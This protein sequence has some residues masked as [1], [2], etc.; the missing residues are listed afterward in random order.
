[1]GGDA[2]TA[3]SWPWI[4]VHSSGSKDSPVTDG[5]QQGGCGGTLVA[6]GW[7][8]TAAHCFYNQDGSAQTV[9]ADTMSVVI[10]EHTLATSDNV[11]SDND[12]FDTK[13][14]NLEIETMIIHESYGGSNQVHDI[15]LLKLKEKLDLSVYMPAC[16]A[17]AATS[18]T[19]ST[20]WVYGWGNTQSESESSSTL[21]ETTQTILSKADCEAGKGTW[22]GTEYSMA[23]AISDDMIC[24]I[25]SGQDS[26]Q[27]DSGGPFT[28]EGSGAHT[29]V[30]VVSWG[31]GCAVAGLPGVYSSVSH[32]REWIDAKIAAAGGATF[33][34]P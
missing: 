8:L 6:D 28:V 5:S 26:C 9:F 15:A 17:P 16:L 25:K 10:G 18:Y 30:G 20:A 2:A 19:G 11:L 31:Y 24:G 32:H 7:V 13:R 29:L 33:C 3:G 12:Q 21:R 34:A 14:K 27:G 23:G 22:Q 4:V 1:V